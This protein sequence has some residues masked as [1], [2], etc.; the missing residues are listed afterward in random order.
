MMFG[1]LSILN[2]I[3]TLYFQLMMGLSGC[4]PI[5]NRGAFIVRGFNVH[6]KENVKVLGK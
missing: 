5:I 1:R 4:N 3:R 2:A 6:L